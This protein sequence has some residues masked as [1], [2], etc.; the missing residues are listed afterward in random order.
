M[1]TPFPNPQFSLEAF[2]SAIANSL[3]AIATD[4][5]V[6]SDKPSRLR[7]GSPAQEIEIHMILNGAPHHV[8]DVVTKKDDLWISNAVE[9]QNGRIGEDL[10]GI[11]YS[12]E[13]QPGK[14]E[15]M[16]PPP[17][18]QEFFD[19]LRNAWISHDLAKV[20]THYSDR[21]LN[22]G[23]KKGEQER[24]IRPTIGLIASFEVGITDFIAE[25]DR[26]HVA[27]FSIRNGEK[28]PLYPTS[29]IKENGEWK[30]YG[31]Q[32]DVSP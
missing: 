15:R 22:S 19:S 27:G 25:G 9:S 28:W 11:L 13:F 21:Y 23:V 10:K 31:N 6:V 18:V 26:A 4:V 8:I 20:M 17:D 5:T 32:R 1:V 24:F 12:I 16:K 14:D 29:I 7:D 3:R 30:W 2:A